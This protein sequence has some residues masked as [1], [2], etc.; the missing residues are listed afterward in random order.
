MKPTSFMFINKDAQSDSLS[1]S[2]KSERI[3]IHSHV[4][5]GR[6]YKK[7]DDG[8]VQSVPLAVLQP[9]KP[10]K[11]RPDTENPPSRRTAQS[12]LLTKTSAGASRQRTHS[13]STDDKDSPS[14]HDPNIDPLLWTS[15]P[16]PVERSESPRSLPIFPASAED[17]FDP[18]NVTCVKVDEAVYGLLQYFL[19]RAHPAVSVYQTYTRNILVH[20][21]WA[22]FLLLTMC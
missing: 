14:R 6:R 8:I 9:G 1:H 11:P 16:V 15:H 7:S 20:V 17:N 18:F 2:K 13:P 21:A 4:Q 3:Q 5:K 12:K 22:N 10:P 19:T